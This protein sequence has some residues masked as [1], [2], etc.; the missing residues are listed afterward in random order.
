MYLKIHQHNWFAVSIEL[1]VVVIGILV[2]MQ[3]ADWEEKKDESKITKK[4]TR[5]LMEDLNADQRSVENSEAYYCQVQ[6][7]G[8]NALTLWAD[9]QALTPERLVISFYQASNIFPTIPL[10]AFMTR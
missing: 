8:K 7:F 3:L 5:L 2:A 9:N 4:Y 6:K 1:A 10:L